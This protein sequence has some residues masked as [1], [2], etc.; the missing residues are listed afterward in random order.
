MAKWW[1]FGFGASDAGKPQGRL[2]SDILGEYEDGI[3]G[4]ITRKVNDF[5]SREPAIRADSAMQIA[6]VSAAVR[7]LSGAFGKMGV[8]TFRMDSTGRRTPTRNPNATVLNLEPCLAYSAV[9][10]REMIMREVLLLGNSYARIFRDGRGRVEQIVPMTQSVVGVDVTAEGRRVYTIAN[11]RKSQAGRPTR[12]D[13]FDVLHFT[14]G[15][16]D[17]F[18][19]KSVLET[20]AFSAVLVAHYMDAFI[21]EHFK[22]GSF[23]E[24]MLKTD[25]PLDKEQKAALTAVWA[26]RNQRGVNGTSSPLLLDKS[27]ETERNEVNFQSA[28]LLESRDFQVTEIARA[29]GVPSYLLAQEQKSTSWGSGISMISESFF[30]FSIMPHVT[31]WEAEIN[32]KL[33]PPPSRLRYRFDPTELLRSSEADRTAM[34]TAGL[35]VNNNGWLTV[36]EIREAEGLLPLDDPGLETIQNNTQPAAEPVPEP[37]PEGGEDEDEG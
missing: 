12:L 28:Q 16:M 7:I 37:E 17:G 36:A 22:T 25:G 14:S 23:Q 10:W 27:I 29:F 13:Q 32:R 21:L 31:R 34:Y 1:Q 20:G 18:R 35:G 8:R 24:W 11:G 6:A 26:R 3:R 15:N 30:R 5:I 2:D 33:A 9:E 19:G 4:F